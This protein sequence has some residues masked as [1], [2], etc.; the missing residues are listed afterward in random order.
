MYTFVTIFF[1]LLHYAFHKTKQKQ[2]TNNKLVNCCEGV[3]NTAAMRVT[4]KSTF[5]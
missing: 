4:A 3:S 5:Y 1:V 2:Q